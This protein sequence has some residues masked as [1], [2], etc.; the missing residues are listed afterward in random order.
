[1]QNM[2]AACF[3]SLVLFASLTAS[4]QDAT[5][6]PVPTAP[7]FPGQR[8]DQAEIQDKLFTASAASRQTYVFDRDQLDHMEAA[9]VLLA[10]KPIPLRSLRLVEDV[11]KGLAV[12]AVYNQG[13][14]EIQGLLVPLG[15]GS[16]GQMID[17]RNISSNEIVK[18][19]V[20]PDGSLL[21]IGK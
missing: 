20:L 8:L 17:A 15:G 6:M 16:S 4:A 5:L 2:L 7:V 11:K 18:A 9:K 13:S 19:K 12:K 14:I 10:G 3:G 21:V 1:M